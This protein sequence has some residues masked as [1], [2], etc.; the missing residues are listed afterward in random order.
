MCTQ[1]VTNAETKSPLK[2]LEERTGAHWPAIAAAEG[3]TRTE[4]NVL[5]DALGKFTNSDS[6]IVA[7]GSLARREF[8]AGSDFDWILLLDGIARPEHQQVAQAVRSKIDDLGRKQPGTEGVFGNLVASHDL[9]HHIG[10]EDDSNSNMTLRILL[11]LESIPIG[12]TDAYDRVLSNVLWRYLDEDRGLWHGSGIYKV[13]RFLFNDV[14]RYWRTMT[15]DFAYKQRDRQNRG[16]AIRNLK[17]RMS[18]KLLFLAGMIACF[19]CHIDFSSPEER[20]EFYATKQVQSVIKRLKSVLSQPPL[21]IIATALLRLPELDN[22]SKKLF[23]AYDSFLSMLADEQIL[24]SGLTIRQHLDKLPVEQLGTDQIASGGRE[25][26]HK[27]RDAIRSI[28]LSP[29]N[30]LGQLTI[31]YGVF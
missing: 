27:F 18:R 5:E 14:A 22:H 11:L 17:L 7:F 19:E 31:E 3:Q 4:R 30:L 16:F 29:D 24:S 6:T 20:V 21:D 23:D 10:G 15:V 13:P 1:N 12:R 25:V 8:T 26:S 28:F 9:V 2:A